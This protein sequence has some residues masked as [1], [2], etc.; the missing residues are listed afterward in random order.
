M[1]RSKTKGMTPDKINNFNVYSGAVST[2]NKLIGVTSE[3]T[4]PNWENMSETLSLAGTSGEID[5]P[6]V[7][8]YKSAEIEISFSNIAKS[9]LQ[10]AAD[11]ATPLILK[12]AQEFINPTTRA[13]EIA[14]RT[15]TICGMTKGVDYGK[16]KKGGFGEPKVKK[17]VTYYKEEIDGEVVTEIDKF[18][19]KAVVAGKDMTKDI[20]SY[21]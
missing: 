7:G 20:L 8:Q 6:T 12:S 14:S 17:E 3:I 10:I 9:T 2:K 21:I 5:S 4:L 19:G 15:I 18:N 16:L 11:D 13:K 1:A